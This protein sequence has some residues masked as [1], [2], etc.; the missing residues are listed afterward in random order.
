M[1]KFWVALLEHIGPTG[2]RAG[3]VNAA[4]AAAAEPGIAAPVKKTA[5][6]KARRCTTV[7][8]P[9]AGAAEARMPEPPA[10]EAPNPPPP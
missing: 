9:M 1:L 4:P 3:I 8:A 2:E 6:T 7:V 5:V 10:A